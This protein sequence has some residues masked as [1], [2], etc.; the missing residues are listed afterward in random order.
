[1]AVIVKQRE[2]A[3]VIEHMDLVG[4]VQD[5]NAIIIDDICDTA[6]T[7]CLAAT[8]LKKR[9]AR[10][11][12]ACVTHPVFSGPALERIKKSD[13]E[14]LI[15][16]NTIPFRTETIPPNITQ[17]SLAPLIAE[18]IQRSLDNV[19]INTVFQGAK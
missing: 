18:T 10:K 13:I 6:G 7:L 15:V 11:V 19:S 14:E 5:C 9:G 17:I 16:T 2:K 4:N 8:E 12:F 3:G 1:M